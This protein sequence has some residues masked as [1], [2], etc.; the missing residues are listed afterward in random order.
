MGGRSSPPLFVSQIENLTLKTKKQTSDFQRSVHSLFQFPFMSVMRCVLN[1]PR[2]LQPK[3]T[4]CRYYFRLRSK[5]KLR[6]V[7]LKKFSRHKQHL[8]RSISIP[9]CCSNSCS[10]TSSFTKSI[11]CPKTAVLSFCCSLLLILSYTLSKPWK[12]SLSV[13]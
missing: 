11:N 5:Y 6:T 12:L 3:V 13:V 7:T 2:A 10:R 4:S 1:N 8:Y 9:F